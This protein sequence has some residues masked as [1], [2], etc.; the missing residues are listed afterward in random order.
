[1]NAIHYLR[2][3][4]TEPQAKGKKIVAHVCNDI[5]R[6]GK[7]FVLAVSARWNEPEAEYHAW[8]RQGDGFALGAVQFVRV[9][10]WVWVANMLAQRGTKTGSNGPPIRYDALEKCLT[11]VAVK[12]SDLAASVHV[13][14]IGCGL[15][16]G[17]WEEVEPIIERTLIAKGVAVYVYD[18]D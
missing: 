7:G 9:G 16:G 1:M 6:W 8:H 18:H 14:R 5:G 17:K 13:P 15:E 10:P 11:Q 3:D 12:A 2:G 4:A